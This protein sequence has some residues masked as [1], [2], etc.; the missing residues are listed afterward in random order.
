MTNEFNNDEIISF[1]L[2]KFPS[3]N[4]KETIVENYQTV[5]DNKVDP[6]EK[7]KQQKMKK[8]RFIDRTLDILKKYWFLFFVFFLILLFVVWKRFF[9]N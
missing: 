5:D 1:L 3:E 4:V 7:Q 9:K 8:T 2:N 6:L